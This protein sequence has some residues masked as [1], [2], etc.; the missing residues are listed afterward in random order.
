MRYRP[1]GRAVVIALWRANIQPPLEV[2]VDNLQRNSY[3]SFDLPDNG[4]LQNYK[5]I[6]AGYKAG[7]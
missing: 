7:R 5:L 4:K 3:E 1:S 2:V 6:K